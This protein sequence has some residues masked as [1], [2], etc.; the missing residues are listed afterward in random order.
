[1]ILI[2]F[3]HSIVHGLLNNNISI[4]GSGNPVPQHAWLTNFSGEL[5]AMFGKVA[6]AVFVMISGYFLVNSSAKGKRI[7]KKIGSIT[8]SIGENIINTI[9]LLLGKIKRTF[10]SFYNTIKATKLY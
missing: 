8:F 5:I 4:A 6:V 1:M 3:H 7:L 10:L 2:V 9:F